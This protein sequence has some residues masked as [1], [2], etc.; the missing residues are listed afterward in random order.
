MPTPI[1]DAPRGPVFGN[2]KFLDNVIQ[3]SQSKSAGASHTKDF[4]TGLSL[5]VVAGEKPRIYIHWNER[6]LVEFAKESGFS[7][8]MSFTTFGILVQATAYPDSEFYAAIHFLSAEADF[9][10]WESQPGDSPSEADMILAMVELSEEGI[11]FY[12]QQETYELGELCEPVAVISDGKVKSAPKALGK[13][14]KLAA[15]TVSWMVRDLQLD[16]QLSKTSK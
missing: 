9:L 4:P 5:R 3:W 10:I 16:E 14:K 12:N 13:G 11:L 7:G 8:A 15:H 2:I 1:F 6:K